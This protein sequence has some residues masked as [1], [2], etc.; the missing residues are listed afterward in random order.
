MITLF[1]KRINPKTGKPCGG[2]RK[3]LSDYAGCLEKRVGDIL[4]LWEGDF[5]ITEVRYSR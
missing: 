5:I 1:G 3:L 2:V 4:P